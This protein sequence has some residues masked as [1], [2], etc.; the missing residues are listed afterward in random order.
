[1]SITSIATTAEYA[2][3]QLSAGTFLE[4]FLSA[5]ARKKL[6]LGSQKTVTASS[7]V[8][9]AVNTSSVVSQPVPYFFGRSY[10]FAPTEVNMYMHS[11]LFVLCHNCFLCFL[12]LP[13]TGK[14]FAAEY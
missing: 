7:P 14:Q 11:S 5:W 6:H 10:Q 2:K 4:Q 13:F 8:S 9:K 1:M 3:R 12:L